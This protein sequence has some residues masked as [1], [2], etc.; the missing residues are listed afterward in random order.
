MATVGVARLKAK[1][2]AFLARVRAG[3][4]IVVTD[5]GVPV[6]RI[7]AIKPAADDDEKRLEHLERE[8][9][10]RRGSGELPPGFWSLPRPRDAGNLVRRA[11]I[12]EREDGR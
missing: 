9:K 5:R 8:G 4:E 11:L 1:L 3:E 6:A 7:V 2:S 12:E 10:I